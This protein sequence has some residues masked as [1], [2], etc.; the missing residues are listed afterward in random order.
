MFAKILT[1]GQ[2]PLK[3]IIDSPQILDETSDVTRNKYKLILVPTTF[4]T[5]SELTKW[6]TIWDW[7]EKKKY[8]LSHEMLY[9]DTAII[10]PSYSLSLSRDITASTGLDVLSHALESIWNKDNNFLT[11]L[12]A[13]E[14]I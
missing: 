13:V 10:S 5:S 2:Y 14:A 12:Y 8:S 7:K 1:N 11:R 3:E 4:G 9:A 6:A